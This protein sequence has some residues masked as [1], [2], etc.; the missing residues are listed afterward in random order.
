MPELVIQITVPGHI[1]E[2]VQ[3]REGVKGVVPILRKDIERFCWEEGR[4]AKFWS[5]PNG[6]APS[7]H[8]QP[9]PQQQTGTPTYPRAQLRN[10]VPALTGDDPGHP[11]EIQRPDR[12]VMGEV[13]PPGT[14]TVLRVNGTNER[15]RWCVKHFNEALARQQ[16]SN[17]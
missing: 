11:Y 2:S 9:P 4:F 12:C 10:E 6:P 7:N 13:L 1:V 14:L 5:L 16:G 3:H 17:L 8:S 15:E